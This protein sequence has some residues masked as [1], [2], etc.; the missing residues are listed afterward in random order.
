MAT[1]FTLSARVRTDAGKGA[2]RRLRRLANELPAIIYGGS[3]APQNI[4]QIQKDLAKAL[5][6]E[7]FYSHV[8]NLNVDG[9]IQPVV[10]RDLQRH[11]S[12]PVLLHA[13][14]QRVDASQKITMRIPM[15]FINQEKCI[16]VRQEGG[17]IS[18][19]AS[20][21][22]IRCLP[23]DLPEYVEVD[24]TDVHVGTILHL[25]SVQLPA[26]VESVELAHGA[27]HDQAIAS[28]MAPRGSAAGEGEE[29][30]AG[31]EGNKEA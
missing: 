5:E 29:G 8:I 12:K 25:S 20:E 21:I 7:A 6:D 13:D 30:A 3:E 18:H 10:L 24:M 11:P 28:V 26:G 9:A 14:F 27:E 16:G 31:E 4:S 17:I 23:K 22:E 2:S 15:H 19:S 1:N